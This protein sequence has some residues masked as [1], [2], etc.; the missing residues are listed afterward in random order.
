MWKT[1]ILLIFLATALIILL[2]NLPRVVVDDSENQ[3][4]PES[5]LP[6]NAP[7]RAGGDEKGM[8]TGVESEL[9]EK[10]LNN[11][12]QEKNVIFADSLAALYSD[13]GLYDSA[14]NY[15]GWIADHSANQEALLQAGNMYYKAFESAPDAQTAAGYGEQVRKYLEAYLQQDPDHAAARSKVAM[16][17]VASDNPMKGVTMLTEILKDDPENEDAL[18]NLGVLSIQSGQYERAVERFNTLIEL[19][20]DDVRAHFYKGFSLMNLGKK[21]DARKHFERVRGLE[22]DPEIK[23][24][25]ENYLNELK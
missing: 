22:A 15:L 17:Y 11:D 13:R 16:T 6:N 10:F 5:T 14:A 8:D 7:Q 12:N 25:A 1:R 2:F 4:S 20:P 21:A 3:E 9:R 24:A 23:A 19:K 18:Y